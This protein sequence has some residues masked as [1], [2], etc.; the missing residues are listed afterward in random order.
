M[1]ID[2]RALLRPPSCEHWLGTDELGSDVLARIIHGTRI[3]AAI[4][5]GSVALAALVAIPA[6]LAAGY[7]SGKVDY[8]LTPIAHAILSSL[9]KLIGVPAVVFSSRIFRLVRGHTRVLRG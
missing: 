5:M 2:P 1:P 4:A 3:E 9:S 6:G 7:L 8:V